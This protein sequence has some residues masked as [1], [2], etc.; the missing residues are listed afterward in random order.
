MASVARAIGGRPRRRLRR[1][2]AGDQAPR[3]GSAFKKKSRLS[4]EHRERVAKEA[5][6]GIMAE[7][8]E[9]DLRA[10][11]EIAVETQV[12]VAKILETTQSELSRLEHR[13]DY[14]LSTLR[15]YIQAL[16]G[17][18]EVVAKFGDKL[19]RLRAV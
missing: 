2:R 6:A 5:R 16:E 4:P 3:A 8:L 18:L 11:R 13:E 10:V 19:V 15:R 7:M 12:E 17:E 1:A 9:G 14:K